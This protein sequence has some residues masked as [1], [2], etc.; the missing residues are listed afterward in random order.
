MRL[1][2]RSLASLSGLR[3]QCCLELWY[4]S[5]MRLKTISSDN[6]VRVPLLFILYSFQ[7]FE[8]AFSLNPIQNP[9]YLM[10][11]LQMQPFFSHCL[12][13]KGALAPSNLWK[14]AE[15]FGKDLP[16]HHFLFPLQQA[17]TPLPSPYAHHW[18]LRLLASGIPITLLF[19]CKQK[20]EDVQHEEQ[21]NN[22]WGCILMLTCF[23]FSS[24]FTTCLL[25]SWFL[26]L[27]S[28]CRLYLHSSPINSFCFIF[29]HNIN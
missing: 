26:V 16:S 29:F 11:F 22:K 28:Q 20:F 6:M 23:P 10:N 21:P 5:Q 27:A 13:Q 17:D 8:M 15:E 18:S 19:G 2:V 4:R 9:F 1:W 12:S 7:K 14:Y 25:T 3:I 24:S